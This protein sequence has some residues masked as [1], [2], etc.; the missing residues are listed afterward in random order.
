MTDSPSRLDLLRFARRVV[1]QQAATALRQI[2]G[3]IAE[4]ERRETERQRGE[5]ARPPAPDWLIQ[6]GLN[7]EH[8]DAVHTGGCWAAKKSGR[9][10]PVS[11]DQALEALR[12]LVPACPHC[13]PDTMLGLLD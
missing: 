4:E 6:H 2:D 13:R 12:Q 5:R 7:R 10:K 1:E 8:V 9:C 11:R 3:W